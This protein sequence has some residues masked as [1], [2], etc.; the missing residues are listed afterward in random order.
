MHRLLIIRH[1]KSDWPEGVPDHER[2]LGRRGE[3]DAPAVGRWLTSEDFLPQSVWVSTA[4]RTRETWELISQQLP[5]QPPAN[6]LEKI[7]AAHWTELL[8]VVQDMPEESTTA[9]LIGHNP[10]CEDL[11]S[12][13]VSAGDQT[14]RYEM[15]YKFPT[16]GVA[17][18]ELNDRWSEISPGT[19][20]LIDFQA[21]RG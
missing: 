8:Q 4:Q 10:G 16:S 12:A 18:I 2:P 9:A 17:V 13:L 19:G 3:R 1:A 7:Y 14:A 5:E 20:T 21:P 11:A 15:A 6:F